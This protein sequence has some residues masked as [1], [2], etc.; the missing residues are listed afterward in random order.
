MVD[1]RGV[2]IFKYQQ[3]ILQLSFG[4]KILIYLFLLEIVEQQDGLK[5]ELI[6][7]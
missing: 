2:Q 4:A 5:M 7:I 1:Y 3:Q 6:G